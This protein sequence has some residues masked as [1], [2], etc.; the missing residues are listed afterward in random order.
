[1]RT[2][3]FAVLVLAGTVSGQQVSQS[4]ATPH[5]LQQAS[6]TYF[7]QSLACQIPSLHPPYRVPYGWFI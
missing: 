5:T 2:S 7:G 6:Y 4:P 3:I 1:M